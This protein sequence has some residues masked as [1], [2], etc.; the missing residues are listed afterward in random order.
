MPDPASPFDNKIRS[1][2]LRRHIVPLGI[3]VMLLLAVVVPPF[4]NI[5]H[6]RRGIVQSIGEG[7]GRPVRADAVELTL[8]PRPAFVLHRFIVEEDPAYGAEPVLMADTVTA[9]LRASTLWHRRVEIATLHFDQPSLNLTR[10]LA[11]HWNFETLLHRSPHRAASSSGRSTSAGR[12]PFPYVEAS[13]ARINFK[14]G[15]EKLPFSLEG[16]DLAV[17]KQSGG[18][19]HLRIRARP[20]RTDLTV[21]DAGQ[22]RGDAV[23]QA[24]GPLEDAP[25]RVNLEWRRVQ[26]GEIGRMWHGEDNNWRGV[27]DWT[28]QVR[29]NLAHAQFSTDVQISEFRR[30]EFVPA[31]TMGLHLRCHGEYSRGPNTLGALQCSAPL[32]TGVLQLQ[33]HGD[34]PL[35]VADSAPASLSL[36][37]HPIATVTLLH[38]PAQFFLNLFRHIHPGVTAQAA[39]SGE[40]NGAVNCGWIGLHMPHSCTGQLES[41][42]L[43]LTLP[44]LD[45]PLKLSPLTLAASSAVPVA[46][47]R[48]PVKTRASRSRRAMAG[49]AVA[50][51][52]VANAAPGAWQLQPSHISMDAA[53]PFTLSGAFSRTALTLKIAGQASLREVVGLAQALRIPAISGKVHASQGTAQVALTM[54]AEWL[55]QSVVAGEPGAQVV[56]F[57]PSQWTGNLQIRNATIAVAA[58]PTPLQIASAQIN[59]TRDAVEWDRI[60]GTYGRTPFEGSLRWHTP[61]AASTQACSRV[62]AL[63]VPNLNAGTFVAALHGGG[64]SSLLNIVNPWAGTSPELPLLHGAINVDSLTL[65]R[66]SIKNASLRLQLSGHQAELLALS[67][68]V[69]GGTIAAGDLAQDKQAAVDPSSVQEASRSVGSAHWGDGAPVYTLRATLTRLQPDSIAALWREPWGRGAADVVFSLT[70]QGWSAADL[71]QHAQGRFSIHWTNGALAPGSAAEMPITFQSWRAA[72]R[73][74]RQAFVLRSSQMMG[75][76]VGPI[77]ALTMSPVS[78]M[79]A[80]PTDSGETMNAQ[81]VTGSVSFARKLDLKLQPSGIVLTGPLGSPTVAEKQQQSGAT[82]DEQ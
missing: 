67:G 10:N 13:E 51:S 36:N 34:L 11:G 23:L 64:S 15:A 41:T 71:A 46:V 54:R 4:V 28:A 9:S 47:P 49:S 38:V 68:N 48:P 62:F 70:T 69:L 26:L 79:S 17:W 29:G 65:W 74:S 57:A 60:S 27:V 22:I 59:L 58:L 14:L 78:S 40:L 16:A 8:L 72:G 20:V 32:Q 52:T 31:G 43:D 33:G 3:A 1:R 30:A 77:G 61:C 37:M 21:A 12:L 73:L 44:Q 45:H 81:T 82:A 55:P 39:A 35:T 18:E 5:K 42:V 80:P 56:Q 25:I 7:L 63:H 76:N 2:K 50:D 19:W 24:A 6:F 66:V 53:T 75:L